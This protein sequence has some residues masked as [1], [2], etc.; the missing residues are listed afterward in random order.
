MSRAAEKCTSFGSRK[1]HHWRRHAYRNEQTA[2][3]RI[4]AVYS[5][6]GMEGWFREVCTPVD[7][8]AAPPP[9]VTDELIERMLEAGP[10]TTS[11]GSTDRVGRPVNC[12]QLFAIVRAR[13]RIATKLGT[14]RL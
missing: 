12:S 14:V 9:P 1:V 11:S 10:G 7:D 6:A 3:A 13:R 8:R 4:I 2:P 5:P